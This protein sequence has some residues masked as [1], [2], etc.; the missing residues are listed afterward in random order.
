LKIKRIAVNILLFALF[1]A[2]CATQKPFTEQPLPPDAP[3]T[4]VAEGQPSGGADVEAPAGG[5]TENP[6]DAGSAAAPQDAPPGGAS[7]PEPA[8][9]PLPD[10]APDFLTIVAVGDNLYSEE[11]IRPGK[12]GSFDFAPFYAEIKPLIEKADIACVN[13]E[14]VLVGKDYS[15]YPRFGTPQEVGRALAGAGF[16]VVNQATNHAM[17]KDA[18]AVY[19][20]L[21][22]WDAYPEI[23]CLGIHRSA[24]MQDRQVIIEKNNM[25]VGFL[26]YAYGTN[27]LPLPKDKPYLVSLIN[28]ARMAKEIDAIRPN[29]DVLV[30]S[31]HWGAEYRQSRNT[32][33]EQ[34]ARFLADHNVDIII[35]HHPHVLE[36][37]CYID[38]KDGGRTFCAYSLGN[39]ISAQQSNPSLTLLGGLLYLK[40][41]RFE[42]IVSIEE[43]GILPIVT[44][45]EPGYTNFK[46]YPLYAYTDE[47]AIKH[48]RSIQGW[49]ASV[50]HFNRVAKKALG[51]FALEKN[52]FVELP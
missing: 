9:P 27:G 20:T 14:T 5:G 23:A 51:D 21:D 48:M 34:L 52:P 37:A 30:V 43:A 39:F 49:Q 1:F 19:A 50:S 4:G 24:E 31:M 26:S 32:Q 12:D 13:Q 36:D 8:S 40:I 17:D 33:Q 45:F 44:H 18:E 16:D 38:R 41:K 42:G 35:G 10:A 22:F 2:S 7:L 47:L 25:K 3:E 28:T 15:G 46:V 11:M 6:P 29:C